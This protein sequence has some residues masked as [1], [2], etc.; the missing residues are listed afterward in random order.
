[1]FA[2]TEVW[3]L[4]ACLMTLGLQSVF[5]QGDSKAGQGHDSLTA[6]QEKL[7]QIRRSHDRQRAMFRN[8]RLTAR[9]T[10]TRSVQGNTDPVRWV[11]E[12]MQ[13]D[14]GGRYLV[15]T[16][17]TIPAGA[18]GRSETRRFIEEQS[19]DGQR[20]WSRDDPDPGHV[21]TSTDRAAQGAHITLEDLMPHLFW[22]SLREALSDSNDPILMQLPTG[23]CVLVVNRKIPYTS[24]RAVL[25]PRQDF[26]VTQM[27]FVDEAG[28]TV[29]QRRVE[30]LRTGEGFWYPLRGVDGSEVVETTD[31]HL[32][33]PDFRCQIE[34]PKGMQVWDYTEDPECPEVTRYGETAKTL[35]QIVRGR[36][37]FVAGAAVDEK[38]EP[39]A[40]VPIGIS[41]CKTKGQDGGFTWDL[42][43]QEHLVW[44]RSDAQGCFAVEVPRQ[45]QYGLLFRP[46]GLAPVIV[47]DVPV[48]TRDLKVTLV[49]GG[50]VKGRVVCPNGEA[51]APVANAI[52]TLHQA[53]GGDLT[54]LGPG[55]DRM[56]T[57]DDQGRFR[58]EH[59]STHMWAGRFESGQ[60]LRE[61][62][63]RSGNTSQTVVFPDG[64][65]VR[66]VELVVKQGR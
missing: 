61:W 57:T 5:A 51:K 22:S 12:E 62:E 40:H 15:R 49:Q 23:L 55:Q 19:F 36:G 46:K 6:R 27:D 2:R 44:A 42:T 21:R 16:E 4:A 7:A 32:N 11:L 17:T 28:R 1:M 59:L 8:M 37:W 50:T 66:E 30:Y 60:R 9:H 35:D 63:L 53:N 10:V 3:G 33:V 29:H 34:I 14:K 48:N 39:V 26:M 18:E 52:V 56:T 54:F 38:G 20:Y 45:G 65:D 31:F 24:F 41:Y 43:D 64:D 58:F 47:Y 13:I 25:D